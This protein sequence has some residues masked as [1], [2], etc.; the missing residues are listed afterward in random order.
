MEVISSDMYI[1]CFG[2]L[3]YVA[4][5]IYFMLDGLIPQNKQSVAYIGEI[6]TL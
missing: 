1:E 4:F 3:E 5:G 6:M 2:A